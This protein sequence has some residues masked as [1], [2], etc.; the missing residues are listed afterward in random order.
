MKQ[1]LLLIIMSLVIVQVQAQS[2]SGG[3]GISGSP[4]QI[5]T[6]T[7]LI[8][9]SQ[10]SEDWN[11]YF[12]QT[13][14]ID[15][16]SDKTLVDWDGDGTASWDAGDQPGF[17]PIGNGATAFTGN[18]DGGNHTIRYLHI[19]LPGAGTPTG[20][21]GQ[22]N[23]ASI[24]KVGLVDASVTGGYDTGIL[25]GNSSTA[26]I[27]TFNNC[28]STGS[29]SGI[30]N[31]GGLV[32]I[33]QSQST[34]NNS[35]SLASVNGT[36]SAVGG[37][38]GQMASL[39]VVSNCYSAGIVTA[40][41]GTTH[42]GGFVGYKS[43][44]TVSNSFWDK[45]ASGQTTSEAGT[46]LTT[47]QMKTQSTFTS[48][49]FVTAPIWK[50][51]TGDYISYPYLNIITYDTPGTTPAVN[52][53]P[54]LED[55][56]MILTY[57]V[58][59]GATIGLPLFGTVSVTI[60]WG[61][62]STE[63]QTTTGFKFHTYTNAGTYTVKISGT[64]TRF[65]EAP[66]ATGYHPE[67]LT[68]VNSFGSVGLIS[69]ANAF[70]DA[71]NLTDVPDK[72]PASVTSLSNTFFNASKLNDADIGSWDVSHVTNM[73][74]MFS[75]ASV[76]NQNISSWNVSNVINMNSLF[77]N[78]SKFDQ[79]IGSWNVGIVTDM[80]GMFSYASVFNQDISSWDVS[81]VTDMRWM[82][83]KA[84]PF[85]QNLGNWNIGNVTNM[86]NMFSSDIALSTTNY[87]A[88][89]NG[90]AALVP[91]LKTGVTLSSGPYYTS[92]AATAHQTLTG[93]YSWTILDA[94]LLGAISSITASDSN[95]C[96]G[97]SITL[98]AAG[99]LTGYT[100]HWYTGSCGGTEV[101]TGLSGTHSEVITVS[102]TA[103]TTYYA[104]TEISGSYSADCASA[105]ITV[106]P[107]LQY[108]SKQ[109]GSWTTAANWEQYNGSSWVAA[110]SYPGEISN[111]CSNPWVT[112][113][114]SHLMEISNA[115]ISIPNL[116]IKNTGKLTV[117]ASGKITLSNQL[118]LEQNSTG[119]IVIE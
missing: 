16:G 53:I 11:K 50:I 80:A 10:H 85:N 75:Y 38:I 6:P 117:K 63:T 61:D 13:A 18:Y 110:T 96:S 41:G 24:S 113:Q 94:G 81:K 22:T 64:L 90:W 5:A 108:R 44:G 3:S 20:F 67:Y 14:N 112:I 100:V 27:S 1:F 33:L 57:T 119:A 35:Y 31:T 15:F 98:T 104:K 105:T 97:T 46:G 47:A 48:W 60:D 71:T 30:M 7:D 32:G 106:S 118:I 72:L 78:A 58:T 103:T 114:T 79:P 109:T 51:K 91:N 87:N 56:R 25:A 92:A 40:S 59:A 115:T 107:L 23:A 101:T 76:F 52:P 111:G 42:V 4:Y 29:V 26:T 82:F 2:Y 55:A 54:G 66:F 95:P 116:E 88:L 62:T 68:A 37:L 19:N 102:P 12:I 93:T 17:S 21:F 70:K 73:E 49:D 36:F 9:L 86:Q 45:Q 8:Y 89:L 74:S 39:S 28:Y 99:T 83:Y 69:L 84:F 43:G 77:S 34:I 65:G